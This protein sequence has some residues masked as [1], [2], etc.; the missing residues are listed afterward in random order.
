[1][2]TALHHLRPTASSHNKQIRR[3][4]KFPEKENNLYFTL[5]G[6]TTSSLAQRGQSTEKSIE[7]IVLKDHKISLNFSQL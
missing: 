3:I 7:T 2:K 5:G 1:M 6:Q 4:C